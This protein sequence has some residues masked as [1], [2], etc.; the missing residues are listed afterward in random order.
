MNQKE[1][2]K[3]HKTAVAIV[4]AGVIASAAIA[5]GQTSEKRPAVKRP[6]ASAKRPPIAEKDTVGKMHVSVSSLDLRWLGQGYGRPGVN[7]ALEGTG[8]RIGG[9]GFDNGISTHAESTLTIALDGKAARFRAICGVDDDSANSPA[10]V[11][12]HL[13]VD[14]KEAWSS[15]VMKPGMAGVPVDVPLAGAKR[16]VLQVDDGG[17]GMRSDH[18]DWADAV[19]DYNG[20]APVAIYNEP[21]ETPDAK[22]VRFTLEL[23]Y[24]RDEDR[25]FAEAEA[26]KMTAL[27]A[28]IAPHIELQI[29]VLKS[30]S[31]VR[32]R[33]NSGGWHDVPNQPASDRS[34][35]SLLITDED[36]GA[37]GWA[38]PGA[39][40][41]S[42]QRLEE[43]ARKG[44]NSAD[45]SLHEWMHT[46]MGRKINGRELGW[47]HDNPQFG[48]ADPDYVDKA[49]DGVWHRWYKYYLRWR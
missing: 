13:F 20:A 18:A 34:A 32:S 43:K 4:L 15:K 11:R 8:L 39:G 42:K 22:E 44:G 38:G 3:M 10:S 1:L 14:G 24:V 27:L 9:K 28:E 40:C 12:F 23:Y 45:I 16:L 26:K 31:P 2:V 19:I 35:Q 7:R 29:K 46:I 33:F 37:A 25:S 30:T 36:I 48:F 17:D 21:M 49:G 47:L 5:C 41:L 6:A